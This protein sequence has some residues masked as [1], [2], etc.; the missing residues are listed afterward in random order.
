MKLNAQVGDKHYSVELKEE[1]GK[2]FADIDGRH[3]ELDSSEPEPNVFLIKD[4]GKVYEA[5]VSPL[6]DQ[7]QPVQVRVGTHEFDISLLDPKRLRS[8]AGAGQDTDGRAEIKT[9][10]PGKVVRILK[11][12][13]EA[14]AKGE[15]VMVVEAMKMQN[16]MKS[17]K[18]GFVKEIRVAEGATVVA[19]E[20]L[21]IVE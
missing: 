17:P 3:Y 21:V 16:E 8:S 5:F 13:G 9:A 20:I 2:L 14:V 15:G 11:A 10:M 18:D 1:D 19:S 12:V 4:E 7:T 6:S